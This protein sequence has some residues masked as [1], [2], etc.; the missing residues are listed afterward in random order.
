[1][2]SCCSVALI[3]YES[4]DISLLI[5]VILCF[6]T[7]L[8]H[9][10]CIY[11]SIFLLQKQVQLFKLLLNLPLCILG[12]DLERVQGIPQTYCISPVIILSVT[13]LTCWFFL[14]LFILFPPSW[15]PIKIA[16]PQSSCRAWSSL[17]LEQSW[18]QRTQISQNAYIVVASILKCHTL[19]C[20]AVLLKSLSLSL[21]GFNAVLS[22][23]WK[24]SN[25]VFTCML[26]C[27][28]AV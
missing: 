19:I 15:H 26:L 24:E 11:P 14:S 13:N 18:Q 27:E 7:W 12:L 22:L 4:D 21:R 3:V 8:F 6:I 17:R 9:S 16:S 10:H 23:T 20:F 1:M 25:M 28:I 5:S 2:L